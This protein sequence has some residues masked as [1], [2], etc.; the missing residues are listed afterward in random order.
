MTGRPTHGM[1]RTPMYVLW[2]AMIQRCTNP[3]HGR[4]ADYGGRGITVCD[5]WRHDFAAFYAHVGDRPEGMSLDRID[6]D[7]G[8]EPGNVRW[9]SHAE[10]RAN[11]RESVHPESAKTHCP[12]GHPYDEAN[13]YYA[14]KTGWRS[15]KTCQLKT[16]Q[17]ARRAK[18]ETS[19]V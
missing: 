4:F 14:P 1:S 5:Q 17:C 6:N 9:A 19:S 7:R 16:N 13:T 11:R 3:N 12:N 2:T 10:Q 15:C 18:K 8:Y